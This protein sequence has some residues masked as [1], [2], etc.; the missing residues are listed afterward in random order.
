MSRGRG[1]V[2]PPSSRGRGTQQQQRSHQQQQH[3]QR[4]GRAKDV[5]PF[6]RNVAHAAIRGMVR[7]GRGSSSTSQLHY[8]PRT[9]NQTSDG[10]HG[11][12]SIKL[13]LFNFFLL[14]RKNSYETFISTY[15]NNFFF[16]NLLSFRHPICIF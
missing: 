9:Q 5:I 16:L 4:R 10:M 3:Q 8:S 2:S 14:K 11:S 7:E 12:L 1:L 13:K 15:A 6:R